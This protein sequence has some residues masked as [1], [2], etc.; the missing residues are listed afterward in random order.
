MLGR[1]VL[2][3][4]KPGDTVN[5]RLKALDPYL[6]WAQVLGSNLRRFRAVG[7]D[8]DAAAELRASAEARTQEIYTAR[9]WEPPPKT[10]S[11]V[12]PVGS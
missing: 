10:I 1:Q 2:A 12:K 8:A 3:Q 5:Q 9:G 4:A 7:Y 11:G 6:A